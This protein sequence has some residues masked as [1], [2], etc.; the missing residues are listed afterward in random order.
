MALAYGALIWLI[1][2]TYA[3]AAGLPGVIAGAREALANEDLHILVVDGASP[4]GTGALA[5]KLGAE[6]LHRPRKL[7]L[8]SAYV[9]GFTRALAHDPELVCQMDADG[10]HD[11][12]DLPRLIALARQGGGLALRSRYIPRGRLGV[13]GR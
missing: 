5:E 4:D 6:V 12:A 10:S 2:P 13:W 11:P 3:E 9:A 7:G 8:G 1:L